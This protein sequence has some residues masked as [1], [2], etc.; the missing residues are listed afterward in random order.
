MFASRHFFRMLS[1]VGII[2]LIQSPLFQGIRDVVGLRSEKKVVGI[3]A[4]PN[5]A[6]VQ[7]K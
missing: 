2:A 4:C 5:V 1:E 3:A 7:H 6:F